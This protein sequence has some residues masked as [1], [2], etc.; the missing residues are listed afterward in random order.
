MKKYLLILVLV[1]MSLSA[2][3]AFGQVWLSRPAGSGQ[4]LY[5]AAKGWK[6]MRTAAAET[7]A[8]GYVWTSADM[9]FYALVANSST[10]P[11]TVNTYIGATNGLIDV[12]SE[13]GWGINGVT[14]SFFTES[15]AADDTFA[16]EL[17]AFADD[18]RYGPALPVY[19]TTSTNCAVGTGQCDYH[20]TTGTAQASGL[21]VDTISGTDCWPSGVTISDSGNNR[22]C[23]MSFD[24]RG[25]R[26]LLLRTFNSGGTGTEAALIGAV[27]TGM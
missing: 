6:S 8:A 2:Y 20:P 7:A 16:F 3:F 25:C 17:Y 13:L 5:T 24:M 11:S 22:I 9:N 15:D 23:T 4:E 14:I 10:V 21:W 19:L 27:I 12:W 1:A 26:Y 18:S